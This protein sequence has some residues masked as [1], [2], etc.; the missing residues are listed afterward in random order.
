MLLKLLDPQFLNWTCAR[1]AA[2]FLEHVENCLCCITI[3]C[4]KLDANSDCDYYV[5]VDLF[6]YREPDE[7][8][9]REEEE[10]GV[11]EFVPVEYSA[12]PIPIPGADAQWE[13][14][15]AGQWEPDVAS[16]AIPAAVAAPEWRD[17]GL[18]SS[19]MSIS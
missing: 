1:V 8:K 11:A 5:Q 7:T 6:F 16:I 10:G 2:V 9:D 3:L 17:Q 12:P 14:D 19:F 18:F 13:G 4:G 15:A